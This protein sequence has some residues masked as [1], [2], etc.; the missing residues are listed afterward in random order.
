MY[1]DTLT[2]GHFYIPIRR[3][4]RYSKGGAGSG[5][6]NGKSSDALTFTEKRFSY[7]NVLQLQSLPKGEGNLLLT[8]A[9][10]HINTQ[11]PTTVTPVYIHHIHTIDSHTSTT[12]AHTRGVHGI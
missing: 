7:K 12:S 1:K 6:R 3:P 11:S 2:E 4:H 8:Y 5:N 10:T 9:Y